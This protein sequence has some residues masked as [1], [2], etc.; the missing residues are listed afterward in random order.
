MGGGSPLASPASDALRCQ[1][2]GSAGELRHAPSPTPKS[3]IWCA[4]CHQ[5]L[6]L[7]QRRWHGAVQLLPFLAIVIG[8]L[9]A[10]LRQRY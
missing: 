8:V 5:R 10:V 3:G 2:C 9:A 7:H 6:Q 4:A 1:R